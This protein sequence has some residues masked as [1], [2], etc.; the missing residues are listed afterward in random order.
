[1]AS[2][3][4]LRTAT[5]GI[6]LATVCSGIGAP[7]VAASALGWPIV[8]QAETEP[9]CR[10]VLQHHFQPEIFYEDFTEINHNAWLGRLDCLVAGTPCQDFSLAGQRQG[11]SGD[12]GNLTL[13]FIRLV[14]KQN[15][16][17]ASLKMSQGYSQ[18]ILDLSLTKSPEEPTSTDTSTGQLQVSLR[19]A[20]P[21]TLPA[22]VCLMPAT[23]DF[24]K[25]VKECLLSSVLEI[26]LDPTKHCLSK[27]AAQGILKRTSQKGRQLPPALEKALKAIC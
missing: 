3:M 17:G 16:N 21:V 2:P 27:K 10:S 19:K 11:I 5:V 8:F 24:P 25:D 9:F 22:G 23:L 6:R 15:A 4:P 26:G 14:Q 7:E 1:M 13:D 18:P 20:R 12:R